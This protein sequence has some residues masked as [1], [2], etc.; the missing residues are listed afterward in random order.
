VL[1]SLEKMMRLILMIFDLIFP[2]EGSSTLY[3]A[4]SSIASYFSLDQPIAIITNM[5]ILS[6]HTSPKAE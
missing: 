5:R 4:H 3:L 1:S 6:D 2:A